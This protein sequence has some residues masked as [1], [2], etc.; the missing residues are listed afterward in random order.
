MLDGEEMLRLSFTFALGEK[1]R[2][3]LSADSC[4][5]RITDLHQTMEKADAK[6]LMYKEKM[7][8]EREAKE[9]AETALD[10]LRHQHDSLTHRVVLKEKQQAKRKA[11]GSY[12]SNSPMMNG[13]P[14]RLSAN[15]PSPRTSANVPS[16]RMSANESP[17]SSSADISLRIP[18]SA[19]AQ[20]YL[21]SPANATAQ[22]LSVLREITGDIE[23]RRKRA[24]RSISPNPPLSFTQPLPPTTAR[25]KTTT[26][27]KSPSSHTHSPPAT[28]RPVKSMHLNPPSSHSLKSP[29][30]HSHSQQGLHQP[31]HSRSYEP[32]PASLEPN[33]DSARFE[34]SPY[35]SNV[36]GKSRAT[37]YAATLE[38]EKEKRVY[39]PHTESTLQNLDHSPLVMNGPPSTRPSPR[40]HTAKGVSKPDHLSWGYD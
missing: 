16:P 5:A 34:V 18:A 27:L 32:Y 13:I 4:M 24:P 12:I 23:A 29:S 10:E 36:T 7:V 31:S 25:P 19:E 20:L 14:M 35:R 8:S 39:R 21:R 28:A 30:S 15:I 17:M 9:K 11:R 1:E 3:I 33:F 40:A 26:H 2:A 6:Q 38:P 37:P 22:R